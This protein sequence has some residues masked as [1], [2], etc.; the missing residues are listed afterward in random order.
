LETNPDIELAQYPIGVSV[1]CKLEIVIALPNDPPPGAYCLVERFVQR[2]MA[3][4][5]DEMMAKYGE[6]LRIESIRRV[7]PSE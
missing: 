1:E 5:S 3:L 7:G 6:T 2:G 4:V